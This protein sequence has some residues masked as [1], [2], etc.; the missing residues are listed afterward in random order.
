MVRLAGTDLAFY[1]FYAISRPA[2][3]EQPRPSTVDEFGRS[4]CVRQSRLCNLAVLGARVPFPVG[5]A[6]LF[7]YLPK[8]T[9]PFFEPRV[10]CQPAVHAP[11]EG[12]QDQAMGS[13]KGKEGPFNLPVARV[14]VVEEDVSTWAVLLDSHLPRKAA[15][16]FRR[17]V[18]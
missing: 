17:E 7:R 14:E 18:D 12:I 8:H 10:C 2:G 15:V 11:V 9:H 16:E 13:A 3:L 5:V 4:P 6:E 1:R